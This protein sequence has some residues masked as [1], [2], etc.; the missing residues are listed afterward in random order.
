[1]TNSVFGGTLSLTQSINQQQLTSYLAPFSEI[2]RIT[3]PIFVVDRGC[4]YLTL[5]CKVATFCLNKV[6]AFLYR[7]V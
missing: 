3:G 5:S 1:M 6:E 2:W 7:M 4:L